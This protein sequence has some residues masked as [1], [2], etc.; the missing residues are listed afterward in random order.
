M[1]LLRDLILLVPASLRLIIH[2]LHLISLSLG[3]LP[4]VLCQVT[5]LTEL[6]GHL[7]ELLKVTRVVILQGIRVLELLLDRDGVAWDIASCLNLCL[8]TG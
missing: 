5:T 3:I 2:F 7:L 8:T 1:L 4:L 6:L